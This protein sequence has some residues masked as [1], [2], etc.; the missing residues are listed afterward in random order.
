MAACRLGKAPQRKALILSV[1]PNTSSLMFLTP[2]RASLG[3]ETGK[4]SQTVKP[5]SWQIRKTQK[6]S[7]KEPTSSRKRRRKAVP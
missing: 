5:S 1:R 3:G 4:K 6:Y 7:L 2:S